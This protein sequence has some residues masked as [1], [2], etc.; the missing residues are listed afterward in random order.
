MD[1]I[2]PTDEVAEKTRRKSLEV[3]REAVQLVGQQL[4]KLP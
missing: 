2:A 4:R 1:A 3:H